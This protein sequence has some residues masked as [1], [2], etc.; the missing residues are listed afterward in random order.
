[1]SC[2]YCSKICSEFLCFAPGSK[3][4]GGLAGVMDD[5]YRMF[6][7]SCDDTFYGVF[8]VQMFR[9]CVQ[10]DADEIKKKKAKAQKEFEKKKKENEK[11]KKE[12]FR[13]KVEKNLL[14]KLE[15][16]SLKE[17]EKNNE[18]MSGEEKNKRE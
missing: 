12:K 8:T 11:T 14:K 10:R 18:G 13:K 7:L 2:Y 16:E 3:K 5:G 9:Q 1:M 17:R 6:L 4:L 15:D